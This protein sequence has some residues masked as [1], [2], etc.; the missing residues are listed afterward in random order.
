V[1]RFLLQILAVSFY[2]QSWINYST[3][4]VAGFSVEFAMLNPVGFYFYTVYNLQGLVDEN[5]GMTGTIYSNDAFFAV[6]AFA[7]ASLQLTQ[8]FM[9][10]TGKQKSFNWWVVAFLVFEF[11]CVFAVFGVELSNPTKLDQNWGTI[12]LCGYC[13][14]AITL[15]KY[16]PQVYLNWKRKSTVGWSLANVILDFCGGFFSFMQIIVDSTAR[17]IPIFGDGGGQGFNIV[18]FLL[19]VIAMFF[20]LIFLF[21]HYVLY[22]DKW[23]IDQ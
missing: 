9:Y 4:S 22:R 5:I 6:H 14:A 1:D 19:S 2:P 21:Q 7:L 3:K 15:V 12:R 11:I 8:I 20:D 23:A 13:K 10:D 16:M 17:G 18:K